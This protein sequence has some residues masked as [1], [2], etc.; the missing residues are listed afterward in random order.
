MDAVEKL[1][2]GSKVTRECWK[3]ELYFSMYEGRIKSFRCMLNAFQYDEEIMISEDWNIDD[4]PKK[5]HFYEIIPF[6]QNGSKARLL[7]WKNQY[8]Y[9]DKNEKI[10]IISSMNT[11]DFSPDFQSFTANDWIEIS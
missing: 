4:D 9:Y 5:Y 7:D 1:K 6:L 10:L 3:D 8:I 11:I 2:L